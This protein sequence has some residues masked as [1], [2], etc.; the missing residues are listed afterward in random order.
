MPCWRDRGYL[1][2]TQPI[3]LLLTPVSTTAG[4]RESVGLL[5]LTEAPISVAHFERAILE[6]QTY[7]RHRIEEVTKV[8]S[9]ARDPV[10]VNL[11]LHLHDVMWCA[12]YMQRVDLVRAVSPVGRAGR[13]EGCGRESATPSNPFPAAPWRGDSLSVAVSALGTARERAGQAPL[14]LMNAN[15]ALFGVSVLLGH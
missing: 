15:V 3:I 10:A 8:A 9:Q 2:A 1:R 11:L 5:E 7:V 13:A 4:R 6:P 14:S 12:R